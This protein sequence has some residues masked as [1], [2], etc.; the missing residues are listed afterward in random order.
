MAVAALRADLARDLGTRRVADDAAGDQADGSEDHGT[1]KTAERGIRN[2]F[3]GVGGNRR[4][5][6]SGRHDDASGDG[7]HS[8]P[9]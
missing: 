5:Q 4:E 3:T 9:L 7:F 2:A 1:G 8:F 6:K